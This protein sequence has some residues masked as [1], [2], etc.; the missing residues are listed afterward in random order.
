MSLKDK[1]KSKKEEKPSIASI[2]A[3]K[4]YKKIN[5][6][7]MILFALVV[8]FIVGAIIWIIFRISIVLTDLIWETAFTLTDFYWLPL[9][10]CVIGGLCIGLFTKYYGVKVHSIEEVVETVQTKGEFK[11][12]K[13]SKA[14][15]AF[16]LPI[17]FGGSIGPEAGLTSII[18]DLC[19][20]ANNALK[21]AG[22]RVINLPEI[23]LSAA[24][25]SIFGT[26]V[27]GMVAGES[28]VFYR[29]KNEELYNKYNPRDYAF[30][31][32]AKLILY[33]ASALGSFGAFILLGSVFP[34]GMGLPRF[35]GINLQLL[36]VVWII[37]C[38]IM[39]YIGGLLFHLGE[40]GFSSLS[41][42]LE[43]HVIAKP[44]IAGII[45]GVFGCILPLVLFSGESNSFILMSSWTG[46]AAIVLISVGLIKCVLTP[47]CLNFG[48]KGGHFFPCIFAGIALG[49]GIAAFSGIDP[50]FCVS[51]TTAAT[52]S[53]IQRRPLLVLA[54]LLL[55]FPLSNIIW[56]GIACIIGCALPIPKKWLGDTAI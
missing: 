34:G 15:V 39:G 43:E 23:T 56:L 17:I 10:I 13:L 38:L 53:A 12:D 25:S 45:L 1:L 46:I 27:I 21:K 42:K 49:Y 2:D 9:I 52:L 44:V 4:E 5:N 14:A 18:V 3:S 24:V 29:A 32:E 11:Y 47:L 20:R 7:G 19:T 33:T 8:G 40:Y 35:S 22:I 48:W 31:R 30:R 26:P 6:L 51:V 16:L 36:D 50:M 41:E 28:G 55:C 54:L 37:P